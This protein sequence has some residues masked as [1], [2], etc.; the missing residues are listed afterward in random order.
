MAKTEQKALAPSVPQFWIG[1]V[2]VW[3]LI[4]SLLG[5]FLRGAPGPAN[6]AMLGV[7]V[8]ATAGYFYYLRRAGF[9]LGG[10]FTGKQLVYYAV[11][12][13]VGTILLAVIL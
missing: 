12:L 4:G 9:D 8:A 10:G 11:L 2:I 6:F 13:G 5:L 7:S 1:V 3:A